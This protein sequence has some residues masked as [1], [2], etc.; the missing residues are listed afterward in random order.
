MRL[1]VAVVPP[2]DVVDDLARLR[3]AGDLRRV[4]PEQLHVTLRFLG[5]VPDAD[6]DAVVGALV[7]TRLPA[8]AVAVAGPTVERLGRAVLGVP[9]AGLD[10]VAAQV[11]V[12][13]AALGEPPEDRPFRGHVTLARA[14]GRRGVVPR[15]AAGQPFDRRWPV[16]GVDLVRS[17]LG[18]GGPRY[19][20]VASFPIEGP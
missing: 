18:S 15:S 5:E 1:F 13:T 17:H 10:D 14:R 16:A 20:V 9:V 7:A 3:V 2:E 11:T 12:A 4:R 19:E 8:G 6:L